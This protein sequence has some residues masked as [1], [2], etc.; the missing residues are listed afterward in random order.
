M[1][2]YGSVAAGA[3][4]DR[5]V[6]G[7]IALDGSNPTVVTVPKRDPAERLKAAFVGQR[8]S[9]TPGDSTQYLTWTIADMTLSIYGWSH[10]GTDPTL[11]ASVGT[12]TV[13][14]I[15]IVGR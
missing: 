14:Y 3:I 10:N 13:E 6:Y 8:G 1:A 12:E 2:L 4:G 9:V 11:V 7:T 15:V 5:I